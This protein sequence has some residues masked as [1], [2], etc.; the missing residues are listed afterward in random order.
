MNCRM[1]RVVTLSFLFFVLLPSCQ[2]TGIEGTPF[3]SGSDKEQNELVNKPVPCII[4]I[5]P[6]TEVEPLSSKNPVEDTLNKN[7]DLYVSLFSGAVGTIIG[8]LLGTIITASIETRRF[9][10]ERSDKYRLVTIE[11]SMSIYQLAFEKLTEIK[12]KI[13]KPYDTAFVFTNCEKWWKSNCLSLDSKAS[14]AFIN[15]VRDVNNGT[16]SKKLSAKNIERLSKQVEQAINL[17]RKGVNLSPDYKKKPV[18]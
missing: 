13:G 12:N 16:N 11:K 6:I 2:T 3:V 18:F 10:K 5:T 4:T 1:F 9:N 8:G 17:L 14:A 15:A 7:N